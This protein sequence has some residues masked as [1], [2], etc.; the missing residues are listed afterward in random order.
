MEL[1][2]HRR[3]FVDYVGGEIEFAVSDKSDLRPGRMVRRPEIEI[4]EVGVLQEPLHQIGRA[5][6]LRTDADRGAL[7]VLERA[8]GTA[9]AGEQQQGFGWGIRP[10]V[11]MPASSG[12]GTPS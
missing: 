9:M 8:E 7:Q 4:L 11:W 5:G 2:H 6:A 12:T 10:S 1:A 3:V